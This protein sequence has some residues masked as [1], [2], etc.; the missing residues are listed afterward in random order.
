VAK[1]GVAGHIAVDGLA[2]V[3]T[4]LQRHPKARYN[5]IQYGTNDSGASG[6]L[7]V[8]SGEGLNPGNTGYAGSFKDN[9]QQIIT[10]FVQAG[11]TPLLAK[12]PVVIAPCASCAPFPDPDAEPP[13]SLIQGYNRVIDELVIANDIQ[14]TPPDFY[15]YFK[16]HPE[17]FYDDL[18]PNGA[19]YQAM[20][21]LWF[22]AL[23]Q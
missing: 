10:A 13:N 3:P 19:G 9:M 11:Q 12:V 14:V 2:L 4:L 7:P 18:H 23:T 15:T 8:P 22:Q 21:N 16:S 6:G 17:E 5:L 1:E 20:A